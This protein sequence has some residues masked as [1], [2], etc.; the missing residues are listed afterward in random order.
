MAVRLETLGRLALEE[1]VRANTG[2]HSQR[3]WQS[4]PMIELQPRVG[5]AGVVTR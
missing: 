5:H 3:W 1:I 4:K 2:A